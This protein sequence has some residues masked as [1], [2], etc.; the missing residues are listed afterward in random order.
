MNDLFK[1][2]SL[3]DITPEHFKLA[4]IAAM[5]QPEE[6]KCLL[7]IPTG[8]DFV[9]YE[10]KNKA[11]VYVRNWS[12]MLTLFIQSENG[13]WLT[14]DHIEG[15]GIDGVIDEA[16]RRFTVA[17]PFIKKKNIEKAFKET[18]LAEGACSRWLQG[19]EE[20]MKKIHDFLK[21][22]EELGYESVDS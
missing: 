15:M 10:G 13:T 14:S 22:Q 3:N 6:I 21:A 8:D 7:G 19:T 4:C 12:G 16:Y 5:A 9:L 2:D 18:Q 20:Y 1:V 11:Y 17:K